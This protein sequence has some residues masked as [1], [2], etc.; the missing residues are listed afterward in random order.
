MRTESSFLQ[1]LKQSRLLDAGQITAASDEVGED[2]PHLSRCLVAR[3]LLTRFQVRELYRGVTRFH[4][5]KYVVV[6]FIGRGGHSQVLKARHRLLSHRYAALKS[7][8]LCNLHQQGDILARFRHEVDIVFRLDHRNIVR[9]YD[10]V[11][12]RRQLFLVLEYVDGCDLAG[13][14]NQFGPL[15]IADA[16]G[17]VV[18]AAYGLAYAH[19]SGIVHRDIKP[20]NLLLARDGV[21]KLADLGLAQVLAGDGSAAEKQQFYGGTPEF[22][23]PE[24]ARSDRP[25]DCRSD[26]YSLGATL[27]HLLTGELPVNGGSY[28]HCL[29]QL[30]TQPPRPLAEA[31]P[32]VPGELAEV[33]DGMR[34]M[35]P[36]QRPANAEQVIERLEPFGR[37]R[38]PE[39]DPHRWDGRM[40]AALVL[41]LL[42]GRFSAEEICRDHGLDPAELERWRRRFLEGAAHALEPAAVDAGK[43]FDPLQA[44]YAKIGAQALEIEVLKNQKATGH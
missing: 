1:R 33:V 2:E 16:V 41:D 9:A 36:E 40:K 32:G 42:K 30:L 26:L 10:V 5:D 7:Y 44:L 34:A 13:L 17:Y 11:Q 20:A 6:D 8:D 12:T 19:R 39:S 25:I 23:A 3:G 35:D 15:P 14:V 28:F 43:P 22:M 18:Q 4:V 27:F 21:V 31:R 37:P 29:K 24:Q 38:P